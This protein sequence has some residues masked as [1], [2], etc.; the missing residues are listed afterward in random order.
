[1]CKV[2]VLVT[3]KRELSTQVFGQQHCNLHRVGVLSPRSQAP[4]Q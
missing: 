2:E 1:M 3:L 4:T